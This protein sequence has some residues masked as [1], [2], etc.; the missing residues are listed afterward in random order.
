[1]T[2]MDQVMTKAQ[3][4]AEAISESETYLH[5]KALENA[6]SEDAEA[7]ELVNATARA[8]QRVEDLLTEKGMDPA[9]LL[10]ANQEMQ[11]AEKRMNLNP[12]VA[13]LKAAR[14]AFSTMMDNVNR[15]L[16][17]VITGELRESDFSP[18]PVSCGGNC[19][20]CNGCG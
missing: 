5:M 12:K 2:S 20:G 15:A 3:E 6:L 18:N 13:E 7:A 19:A 16:R 11:D 9:E 17:L 1:M 10:R 4:L 14:K 8:R